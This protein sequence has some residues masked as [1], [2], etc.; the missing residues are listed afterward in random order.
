M[1]ETQPFTP[2][3]SWFLVATLI[4]FFIV[5][6]FSGYFQIQASALQADLDELKTQKETLLKP[7]E[8]PQ[9]KEAGQFASLVQTKTELKNI[10]ATQLLWS[11]II[12]KIENTVPK[13]KDTNEPLIELRSYNGSQEGKIA[14]SA[15]TRR[16]SAD[17]FQDVA[18]VIRAFA[19]DTSFK[20]VFVPSVTKS[21]TPDGSTVLSF[22]M[23][24]E[25]PPQNF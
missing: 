5:A 1:I 13:L 4:A 24:L 7:S 10:E 17:P 20:N 18:L 14:V 12:E 16:D 15:T 9:E 3:R 19:T 6:G 22:S 11:K 23:N 21:L 8:N 2:N 25:Y